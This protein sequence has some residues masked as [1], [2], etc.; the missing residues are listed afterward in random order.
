MPFSSETQLSRREA[1]KLFGATA[2]AVTLAATLPEGALR[3]QAAHSQ[4]AETAPSQPAAE[5]TAVAAETEQTVYETKLREAITARIEAA[6]A[7]TSQL[8]SESPLTYAQLL[9][10]VQRWDEITQFYMYYADTFM[11]ARAAGEVPTDTQ[12]DEQVNLLKSRYIVTG[13]LVVDRVLGKWN[14]QLG[15][16]T[17]AETGQTGNDWDKNISP[18]RRLTLFVLDM[19]SGKAPRIDNDHIIKTIYNEDGTIKE[20]IDTGKTFNEEVIKVLQY[21]VALD[22]SLIASYVRGEES[23]EDLAN[24]TYLP[25]LKLSE[26]DT[27]DVDGI[28]GY[29]NNE[30]FDSAA[31]EKY[32]KPTS[33]H[34][35]LTFE[36]AA[37]RELTIK[38][39]IINFL[40]GNPIL[41]PQLA[42][43][44]AEKRLLIAEQVKDD[45]SKIRIKDTV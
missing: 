8:S 23:A 18:L 32:T 36:E 13:A 42:Q 9:A 24:P 27:F 15:M 38:E 22:P 19:Q 20:K 5:S 30:V 2:T 26:T 37:K 17:S 33:E 11:L 7:D 14:D 39:R 28:I 29:V 40:R 16:S 25:K 45:L 34:S 10:P 35:R 31:L 21:V 3:P 43:Q 4:A 41:Q 6:R 44:Q 12:V 1:L